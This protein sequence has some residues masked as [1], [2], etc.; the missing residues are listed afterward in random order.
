M[1]RQQRRTE[2]YCLL[3]STG[4]FFLPFAVPAEESHQ[5]ENQ[6]VLFIHATPTQNLKNR[7]FNVRSV[8]DLNYV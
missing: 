2:T 5:K 3:P 4:V 7:I 8:T 1:T 6:Q